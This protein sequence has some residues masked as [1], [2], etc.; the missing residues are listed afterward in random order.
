ME[1]DLWWKT[2][3]SGRQSSVEDNLQWKMTFS[4]RQSLLE[5][6]RRWKKA[7]GGRQPLVDPCMLPS[8]LCGLCKLR[9]GTFLKHWGL[10]GPI[11]PQYWRQK[12][13]KYYVDM[14]P[15]EI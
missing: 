13:T 10:F 12:M 1:D 2:T 8:P 6:D 9:L 7:L 11:Y 14:G 5:D 15:H 3:F 4:G